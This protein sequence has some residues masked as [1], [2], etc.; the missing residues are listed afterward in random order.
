MNRLL[1]IKYAMQDNLQA[2]LDE[3]GEDLLWIFGIMALGL[4]LS[5]K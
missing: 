3:E 5:A 4:F 1:K 2:Y